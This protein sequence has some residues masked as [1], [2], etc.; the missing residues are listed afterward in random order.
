[1]S[2]ED[3]GGDLLELLQTLAIDQDQCNRVDELLAGYIDPIHP[4]DNQFGKLP[5]ER[6]D[7][8][9]RNHPW[10]CHQKKHPPRFQHSLRVVGPVGQRQALCFHV[11]HPILLA[12]FQYKLRTANPESGRAK[13]KSIRRQSAQPNRIGC[14]HPFGAVRARAS[15]HT[16]KWISTAGF[17]APRSSAAPVAICLEDEA[18][19]AQ[20]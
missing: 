5:F 15:F 3:V 11:S 16:P 12:G 20:P 14:N 4:G 9:G 18:P 7:Q 17:D 8:A 1:M 2:A 13:H 19:A 6:K 10:R